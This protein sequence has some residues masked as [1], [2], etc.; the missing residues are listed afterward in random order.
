MPRYTLQFWICG[1]CREKNAP[2]AECGRCGARRIPRVAQPQAAGRAVVYRNPMTGE[3]R[4]PPRNDEVMPEVYRMQGY[5]RHEI[6]NMG[7][8]E[9]ESG[10]VHEGSNWGSEDRALGAIEKR[11]EEVEREAV[12]KVDMEALGDT[13]REL[14]A[15]GITE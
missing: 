2:S 5:E 8:W 10:A 1:A 3:Y 15:A 4:T 6:M 14:Y 11:N 12:P 9:K 13:V 7:A